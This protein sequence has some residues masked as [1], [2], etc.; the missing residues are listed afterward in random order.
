MEDRC[1]T[2]LSESLDP[3]NVMY[4]LHNIQIPLARQRSALYLGR[5]VGRQ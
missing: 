4:V 2:A 5:I 3:N 1:K